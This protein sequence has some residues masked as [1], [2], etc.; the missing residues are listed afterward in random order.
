MGATFRVRTIH[1]DVKD[2]PA[3][4]ESIT[5]QM[6]HDEGH[7]AY[8]GHWGMK[9]SGID[10]KHNLTFNGYEE[11]EEYIMNNNNKWDCVTAVRYPCVIKKKVSDKQK[12]I[13]KLR[14]KF[15][16]L[17]NQLGDF[18]KIG[19]HEKAIVTRVKKAKS[20]TKGCSKCGSSIAVNHLN[21]STCPVCGNKQFIYTATDIKKHRE[22]EEKRRKLYND[23]TLLKKNSKVTETEEAGF[24]WL[25]GGWCSC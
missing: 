12:Q 9:G 13:D 14:A 16:D 18:N 21:D 25:V 10:I 3:R 17:N 5:Q 8:S 1:C 24:A 2:L 11:A 19:E 20:K 15:D 23:L 4:V 7:E 6:F 22:M